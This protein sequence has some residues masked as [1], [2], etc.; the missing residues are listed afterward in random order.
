MN[1][2]NS[3]RSFTQPRVLSA[4]RSKYD[5]KTTVAISK[6]R[7]REESYSRRSCVCGVELQFSIR[8]NGH[9]PSLFQLRFLFQTALSTRRERFRCLN[10]DYIS[11]LE[12]FNFLVF[13]HSVLVRVQDVVTSYLYQ[14]M[15]WNAL[16]RL[17]FVCVA[18]RIVTKRIVFCPCL[19]YSL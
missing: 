10:V 11:K 4:D 12:E 1:S 7:P 13:S 5:G 6:S 14:V 17:P 3:T 9:G 18:P 8:I 15:G 2:I 19:S 16:W